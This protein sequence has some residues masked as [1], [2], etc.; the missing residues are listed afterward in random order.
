MW[1]VVRLQAEPECLEVKLNHVI[2]ERNQIEP[3][4]LLCAK[5]TNYHIQLILRPICMH[6]SAMVYYTRPCC[7]NLHDFQHLL[8]PI[9]QQERELCS[10]E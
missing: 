10:M 1:L 7:L 6:T 2:A 4:N 5:L 3:G 9:Q 8:V